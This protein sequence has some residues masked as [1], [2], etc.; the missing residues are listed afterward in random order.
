MEGAGHENVPRGPQGGG[1]EKRGTRS[2]RGRVRGCLWGD[3]VPSEREQ[4]EQGGGVVFA[5]R[6]VVTTAAR[7][8]SD[9]ERRWPRERTRKW[10][11]ERL[12]SRWF[13]RPYHKGQ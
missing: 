2:T 5:P 4:K 8:E 6:S 12:R 13:S 11:E 1:R 9:S 7:A 3:P 10:L